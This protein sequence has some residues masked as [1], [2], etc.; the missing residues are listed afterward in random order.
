M[1]TIKHPFGMPFFFALTLFFLTSI[2]PLYVTH[3]D[4]FNA[5]QRHSFDDMPK[6]LAHALAK[7]LHDEL[8]STFTLTKAQPGFTATNTVH[9]MEL[10]FT[11]NGPRFTD[12]AG[13]WQYS[14]SFRRW[15]TNRCTTDAPSPTLTATGVSMTYQRGPDLTEWYLNTPLGLE[16]GFTLSAPPAHSP[17]GEQLILEMALSGTLTPRLQGSTLLLCD[18]TGQ[19]ILR[20]TGLYAVDSTGKSLPA[21]L[22]LQGDTLRII[23]Y[24]TAATYP[25][26]IDPWV[27]KSTLWAS[28]GEATDFFGY[29]VAISGDT[30]VVGACYDDIGTNNNQGSAYVFQKA[31]TSWSQVVRLKA[32]DGEAGDC[33]GYSVAISGDTVVV[34]AYGDDIGTNTNQGSAYVFEKPASGWA[35]TSNYTAKLTASD[36][37]ADDCFGISVAISGDTVVVGAYD[38]DIGTNNNQ[39][40]AYVF[41]KPGSG[42][43][44]TSNYTARLTA[45]DGATGDHFGGSVAISGDTVVVGAYGDDSFKGSAYVF[46]LTGGLAPIY[47]LLLGDGS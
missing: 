46:K 34:G 23:V 3:S 20:Y 18:A 31:E 24:D 25:I 4:A 41:E 17:P 6:G 30:V 2:S 7:A 5:Q 22:A 11:K 47:M 27:Q 45:N 8:P 40:S 15:G 10:A 13:A 44:T 35:T 12:P 36:G 26:T 39:G 38:D 42:W 16:Q 21:R 14:M 37:E 1:N 43:A 9:G 32:G 28:D 33:F 19:G 29:S